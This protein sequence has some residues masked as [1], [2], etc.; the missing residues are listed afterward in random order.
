MSMMK[1][2]R[3]KT[4]RLEG[5]VMPNIISNAVFMLV[6]FALGLLLVPFYINQLGVASYAIIPVATS[7]TSYIVIISDSLSSTVSRYLTIDLRTDVDTAKHTY[8]TAMIGFTGLVLTAIPAVL[9]ISVLAP[10]VFSIGSNAVISVQLLFVLILASVLVTVWSNNFITVLFSKNRIDLMNAVKIAQVLVQIILVVFLLTFVST[11]VEYVGVA[12]FAASVVFA[13]MGYLLA[14]RVCPELRV[15][16]GHYDHQKFKAMAVIGGWSL[17]NNLG[18]LLFIQ[19][20][21]LIVNITMGAEQGGYFGIIVTLISAVSAI[22]DTMGTIFAPIIYRLFSDGKTETMNSV[23]V[24]AVKIVGLV[25]SMP[26]AFLCVFAEPVLTLWVGAEYQMLDP[27]V[28]SVMILMVGIGAITPA[29]PLTMVYLKVRVP[30]TITLVMGLLNVVF[31]LLVVTTTDLGLV[32]VGLVWSITMFA[33]NCVINPWYIAR[34][35]GIGRFDIHKSLGYGFLSFVMLAVIYSVFDH[36]VTVPSSWLWMGLL[37][38][39]LLMLHALVVL[40]LFLNGDERDVVKSCVPGP[41]KGI[42]DRLC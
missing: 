30:G 26:I 15:M 29:Y 9:L 34:I 8:N 7:V 3:D 6:N 23:A 31:T 33:K 38:I 17:V 28:W 5:R 10:S 18:N 37:G 11:S 19:T 13:V 24:M 35:S 16:R 21:L 42:V 20:S 22:V 27:I 1:R 4:D 41:L 32:G 39:V 40:R 12:Y 25:T 2:N 14:R 36:F